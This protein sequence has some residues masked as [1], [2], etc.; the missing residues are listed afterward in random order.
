MAYKDQNYVFEK[1]PKEEYYSFDTTTAS[2]FHE[3]EIKPRSETIDWSRFTEHASI[4]IDGMSL[5]QLL[6]NDRK[7]AKYNDGSYFTS[8]KELRDFFEKHLVS[9]MPKQQQEDAL[10]QVMILLS[11]GGLRPATTAA[12]HAFGVINKKGIVGTT[13]FN[14]PERQKSKP[15]ITV[16]AIDPDTISDPV[17]QKRA[18]NFIT[19]EKGFILQEVV[20]QKA[21]FVIGGAERFKISPDDPN[22]EKPYVYQAL[23][24]IDVD[25]RAHEDKVLAKATVTNCGINYGSAQAKKLLDTRGWWALFIDAARKLFHMESSKIRDLSQG[26]GDE[27]ESIEKQEI[28][29]YFSCPY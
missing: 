1:N 27:G 24:T 15:Q 28:S 4:T 8:K 16:P 14:N 11:E 13:F 12:D 19:T 10:H 25:L 17:C 21:L 9:R 6:K 5:E 3:F 18:L 22:G 20:T 23:M 2:P 26:L 29:S 7:F